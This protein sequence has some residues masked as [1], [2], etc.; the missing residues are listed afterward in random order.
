MPS[1]TSSSDGASAGAAL[2]P[3][4]EGA[5]PPGRAS[6]PAPE[7]AY[8][9]QPLPPR[10]VPRI[11]WGTAA[12]V[13]LTLLAVA[14]GGWEWR[15]R[16]L[17]LE[18][19]DLGPTRGAWAIERRRID[20]GNVRVAIVGSSRVLFG[21]DLD[22]FERIA[23][24]RPVQL[25]MQGSSTRKFVADVATDPDF[26]GLLIVD[27]TPLN[28]F[29]SGNGL[30]DDAIEY[31]RG[32]SLTQRSDHWLDQR[33]QQRLA[34]LDGDYRLMKLIERDV[35]LPE[36]DGVR[37]A[38]AGVWK[39]AT[40][41]EARQTWVWDRLRHD[42]R[43]RAHAIA[44]WRNTMK[45]VPAPTVPEIERVIADT[46]RDVEAIRARGGDVVFVRPPS[47]GEL[48]RVE[49]AK[50]PRDR[51]WER[52]L[53]ETHVRGFHYADDPTTRGLTCVEESHLSREDARAFTRAYAAF[54]RTALK[55]SP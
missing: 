47:S 51:V 39:V 36:R 24:V 45:R 19:G 53:A 49:A 27:V 1:S 41:H 21:T 13:A 11:A 6:G 40:T 15:M 26:R 46:R 22:E 30:F 17:G 37:G 18:A 5:R 7:N 29:R 25:A 16:S 2:E 14:L 9:V 38:Y 33:L 31:A 3:A 20:A 28:Y 54:V 23:G 4:A 55:P 12:V 34:Y 48:A 50:F 32:E 35:P 10:R 52:L 44:V 43:L 42:D 8:W